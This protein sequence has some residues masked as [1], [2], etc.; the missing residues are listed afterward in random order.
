MFPNRF[1]AKTLFMKSKFTFV[2]L[3][4]IGFFFNA[5]AQDN[6]D[7]EET[8]QPD[9]HG[10]LLFMV[11]VN[12]FN[13]APRDFEINPWRSKTVGIY[14]LYEIP[15]GDSK[16]SFNAGL[17]LG[18]EKYQFS[19]NTILTYKA[20]N[21]VPG[22]E[23]FARPVLVMD[24]VQDVY[25]T[26]AW[27]KNR[28][29]ANYVD[30]PV[31]FTYTSNKSNP[32]AGLTVALGGKIGVLYAAHTKVK[33]ELPGGDTRKIK[34][35]RQWG[36]NRFRYSALTRV[37]YGGFSVFFEYQL[38]DLFD[39]DFGGPLHRTG[40]DDENGRALYKEFPDI[41]N[42]RIGLAIDLF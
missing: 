29:A 25:N 37:G 13:D 19:N 36:L 9:L 15:L 16:F 26:P 11:G 4:L 40:T 39:T 27:E 35:E 14:Y 6:S 24:S 42:Y 10:K 28:L 17:G 33:Y 20:A 38:S 3:L 41:N 8:S 21:E 34:D 5:S 30:V 1:Q 7:N 18:L 22:F 12:A 31:E 2:F 32:A 23:E